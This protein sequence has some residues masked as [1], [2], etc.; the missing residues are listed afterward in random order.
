MT[1]TL[2]CAIE[3]LRI[4]TVEVAH[5]LRKVA[6]DGFDDEVVV[7][8]HQAPRMTDP[9][10]AL[11]GLG[12]DFQPD[13]TVGIIQENVLAPVT[14]RSHVIKPAGQLKSKGSRHWGNVAW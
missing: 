10:E 5:A 4:D 2:V 3:G 14:T 7:V 13:Q 12:E 1:G 6:L 11:A 8:V 9:V